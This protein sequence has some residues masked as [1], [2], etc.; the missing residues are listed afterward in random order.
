[1]RASSG[2]ALE[3]VCGAST[4]VATDDG[5]TERLIDRLYRLPVARI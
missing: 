2:D 3:V 5:I 4:S 1:M